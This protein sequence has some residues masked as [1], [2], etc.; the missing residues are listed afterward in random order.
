MCR[1]RFLGEAYSVVLL[2][3]DAAG[4][5]LNLQRAHLMVNYDLP[6]NPNRIEQ[7]F[8]RIHRI[9]QREVCHLWNLVAEDTRE[10]DVFIR[11][12]EKIDNM[13]HAYNGNLFNVLGD[14]TAFQS[15]SLKDLLIDAIR[16]GDQPETKAQLNNIID[17]SVSA[18]LD[19]IIKER[20]LNKELFS[21]LNLEDVRNR[22][23]KARQRKL[24]PGFISA[25]FLP[26]FNRLGGR[27]R[28]REHGR[29]E[30]TCLGGYIGCTIG[31]KI[32]NKHFKKAEMI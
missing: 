13:N 5:G 8:G 2:A 22:M 10:G 20:A 12:L 31:I 7:R 4:E 11:L 19:S 1:R 9:G 17:A 23:E 14:A 30:I 25:F 18:G 28:K 32:L 6:W 27:I 21:T 3:T 24:Q 16:Y 26:A 29:F 15:K